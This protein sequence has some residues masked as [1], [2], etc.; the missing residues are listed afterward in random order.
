[1]TYKYH[2]LHMLQEIYIKFH[3]LD[4]CFFVAK[5]LSFAQKMIHIEFHIFLLIFKKKI[6]IIIELKKDEKVCNLNNYAREKMIK[7]R[8]KDFCLKFFTRKKTSLMY[9]V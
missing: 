3:A 6:I 9:S 7:T 4:N 2:D 1:M 8:N 5:I